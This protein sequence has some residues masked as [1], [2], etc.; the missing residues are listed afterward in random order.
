MREAGIKDCGGT[1]RSESARVDHFYLYTMITRARRRC[2]RHGLRRG[3]RPALATSYIRQSRSFS[4][5]PGPPPGRGPRDPREDGLLS[6]R[7]D[8]LPRA[9]L[10]ERERPRAEDD[11]GDPAGVPA[12]DRGAVRG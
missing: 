4:C 2:G 12:P 9:R 10:P 8:E 5:E 6:Q 7:E 1:P 11:R 3:A